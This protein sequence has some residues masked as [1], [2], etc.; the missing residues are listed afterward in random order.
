M[1]GLKPHHVYITA[2]RSLRSYS[3]PN[4]TDAVSF[5]YLRLVKDR[6]D[7]LYKKILDTL[8]D[9]PNVREAVSIELDTSKRITQIVSH[10]KPQTQKGYPKEASLI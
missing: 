9:I 7:H 6:E 4:P 5:D 10:D 8:A 2:A 3:V 1:S